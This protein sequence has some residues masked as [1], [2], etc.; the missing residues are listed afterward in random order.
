MSVMCVNGLGLTLSV[1]VYIYMNMILHGYVKQCKYKK[2]WKIWFL[3]EDGKIH[4]VFDDKPTKWPIVR[5]IKI[6]V[7]NVHPQLIHMALQEG[8]VIKSI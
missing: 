2:I 3:L 5:K 4:N 1:S 7:Y 8:I 6:K